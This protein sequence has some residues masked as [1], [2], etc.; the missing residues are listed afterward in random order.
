MYLRT[1]FPH[2]YILHWKNSSLSIWQLT[3][4]PLNVMKYIRFSALRVSSH[5]L[6]FQSNGHGSGKNNEGKASRNGFYR[7]WAGQA[8][9]C[10]PSCASEKLRSLII[11]TGHFTILW[12]MPT[13]TLKAI[14]ANYKLL[15]V[16]E[17]RTFP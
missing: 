8:T 11:W 5:L 7:W 9:C 14:R 6:I 1:E 3:T 16:K 10:T 12:E 15:C 17:P 13:S 2:D 4:W